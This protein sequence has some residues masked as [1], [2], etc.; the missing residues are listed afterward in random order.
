M[1]HNKALE[2]IKKLLRL[3]ASDNP[4]EAAAAMRQARALM[5]KYRLEESDVHLSDVYECA[6]R[7]GSK[8]TPPQ[9]EANLVGAVSQA[10]ACKVLFMSGI[11]EWRFI[12]ELA[13][14]ASYTMTLLLRQVR[15]S[16]RD[17]I[18]TQL[19]RC[20]PA[21]KTKRADVF[22][23]AW[24]S[25]VRKQVMAFAG[26]DEPSQAMVAYML[27]NHADTEKLDC[28]DRNANKSNG[29]RSTTDAL[30]G[31]IAAGDVRLNHGVN[32]Q[33]QLSLN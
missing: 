10:Y 28:R 33:D 8:I 32:G 17:F 4:H 24:V 21:T 16:R 22:C 9:W 2:K 26:K 29:M 30:Y 15:Q 11:G 23:S 25:A 18:S 3:A 27:K 13:E 12:G 20:K 7:S 1:N 6:A 14:L 19:K 31:I 5:E